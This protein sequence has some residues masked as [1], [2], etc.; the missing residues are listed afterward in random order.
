MALLDK[1]RNGW[2]MGEELKHVW[3]WLD[4]NRNARVDRGE[5][6]NSSVYVRALNTEPTLDAAGNAES[7]QGAQGLDGKPMQT[8]D[9]WSRPWPFDLG[10]DRFVDLD[11]NPAKDGGLGIKRTLSIPKGSVP[12]ELHIYRWSSLTN[13]DSGGFLRFFNV[14]DELYVVASSYMLLGDAIRDSRIPFP[15]SRVYLRGE[16]LVWELFPE[17]TGSREPTVARS[18]GGYQVLEGKSAYIPSDPKS[19]QKVYPWVAELVTL[20]SLSKEKELIRNA[21][22]RFAA[23]SVGDFIKAKSLGNAAAVEGN[24]RLP[25][26]VN[27]TDLSG[28][29]NSAL[30][31]E[32]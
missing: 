7:L 21:Y 25:A 30:R 5:I 16:S 18:L 13:P 1:D 27:F 26:K 19:P 2:L 3:V 31:I 20:D 6:Q 29:P 17:L 22:A 32:K 15:W 8:W 24:L 23:Y 12:E 9:W 10:S 4:K 28:V 14:N 11:K